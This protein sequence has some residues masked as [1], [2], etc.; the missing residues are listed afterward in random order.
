MIRI[1][2]ARQTKLFAGIAGIAALTLLSACSADDSAEQPPADQEGQEQT[3]AQPDATDQETTDTQ[4]D[5]ATSASPE[6]D[7]SP[8]DAQASGDDPVFDIIG[9]VEAEY[10]D[11]FIV[12]IDREDSGSSFDVDV[13]VGNE[14][15]ELDVT[16]DGNITVDEQ[17][18]DDSKIEKADRATVTVTEALNQAF[19]E[20]ADATFDTVDLDDDDGSLRWEVELDGADGSDIELDVPAT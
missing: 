12:D 4:T 11:G 16:T 14:V 17:E 18:G 2:D 7:A 9:F 15:I 1:S 10:A 6:T 13:V 8:S 5:D 3:T 19:E 20:H